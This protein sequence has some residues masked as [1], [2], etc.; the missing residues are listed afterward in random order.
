[1]CLWKSGGSFRLMAMA[2]LKPEPMAACSLSP[3]PYGCHR[4]GH[5]SSYTH[6]EKSL[7]QADAGRE[8]LRYTPA[9]LHASS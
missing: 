4:P 6:L 8:M 9:L 2:S 5:S 3:E 1:M 7:L